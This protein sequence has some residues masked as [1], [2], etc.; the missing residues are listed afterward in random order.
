MLRK[1]AVVQEVIDIT[2]IIQSNILFENYIL[3]GGTALALQIAHRTSTVIDLF[4]DKK[5]NSIGIAEY[6]TKNFKNSEIE[7]CQ[8]DF[9]RVYMNNIKIEI[10]KDDY[11]FIKEPIIDENIKVADKLEISAMKL[12]A[13]MGRTEARDFIDL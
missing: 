10:I 1:E 11:D 4:T 12:R 9:C 13:I 3:A 6:F 7:T 8:D 2:K 5:Q